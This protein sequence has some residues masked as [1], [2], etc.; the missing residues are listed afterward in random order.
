VPRAYESLNLALDLDPTFTFYILRNIPS[1][2][3]VN[4]LKNVA[5][6]DLNMPANY[7]QSLFKSGFLDSKIKVFQITLLKKLQ[8]FLSFYHNIV[9]KNNVCDVTDVGLKKNNHSDFIF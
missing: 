1:K 2:R 3:C 5:E 7:Y 9:C 8:Y 6:I 4:L